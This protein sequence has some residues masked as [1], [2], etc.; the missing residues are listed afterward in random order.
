MIMPKVV[1]TLGA[2]IEPLVKEDAI[3]QSS[4]KPVGKRP[5]ILLHDEKKTGGF[6]PSHRNK[7][8]D[9][10]KQQRNKP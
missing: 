6:K 4:N 1:T 5:A 3:K 8:R 7:E 10:R 2:I 9:S